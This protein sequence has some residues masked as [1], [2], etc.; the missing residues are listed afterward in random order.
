M[1]YL[2]DVTVI[3][4]D[5]FPL[6]RVIIE[7]IA[8]FEWAKTPGGLVYH[9]HLW[10]ADT[11]DSGGSKVYTEDIYVGGF[12]YL[13]VQDFMEHLKGAPWNPVCYSVVTI[14]TEG[15]YYVLYVPRDRLLLEWEGP[16]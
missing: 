8:K 3:M 13:P 7:H 9:A 12:D 16:T 15:N 5:P 10:K 1:S 6:R 14:H 4:R 11:K 2:S